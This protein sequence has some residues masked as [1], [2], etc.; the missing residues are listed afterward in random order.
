MKKSGRF[1]CLT[2]IPTPYRLFFFGHLNAELA[3]RGWDFEA[4]FM[5]HS[6]PGRYWKFEDKDF[7][8]RYRILPGLS[9]YVKGTSF[10][11]NPG[12]L[13]LLAKPP[14]ILLA[15]GAWLMPTTILA[16]LATCRSYKVFWSESQFLSTVHA[17]GLTNGIRRLLLRRYDAFAVPGIAATEYIEHFVPD[18]TLL[19]LP[20]LVDP[21]LYRDRVLQLREQRPALRQRFSLAEQKRVL[22][23]TARLLSVK[24]I[25]PFLNALLSLPSELLRSL[26]VLIAGEGDLRYDIERWIVDHASPQVILLGQQTQEQMCQLY[27]L[28]DGFAL[29]SY[30]DPN[31]LSVLEALW[32][33][34][35]LV[36]SD[37]VGNHRE[38]LVSHRNGWLF[39]PDDIPAI[40]RAV[41]TWLKLSESELL[42]YRGESYTIASSSFDPKRVIPTFVEELLAVITKDSNF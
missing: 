13:R 42:R 37:R 18:M 17:N 19:R 32:A 22:L 28:S 41:T 10:H 25:L 31:P 40:C 33:A 8:F 24:G 12:F 3:Q 27:A 21:A 14:D 30:N 2:N 11:F 15:G 36:L 34:L 35:P 38:T 7:G 9:P 23:I 39:S 1:V 20:N 5:A 4:W 26:T 6:E 16:S 29:P